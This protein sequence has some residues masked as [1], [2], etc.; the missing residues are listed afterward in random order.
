MGLMDQE[1]ENEGQEP[2]RNIFEECDNNP[3]WNNTEYFGL[4]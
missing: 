3:C 2:M 4:S 1:N